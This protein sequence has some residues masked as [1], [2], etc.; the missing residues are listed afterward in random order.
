M[1]GLDRQL[2]MCSRC[3]YPDDVS[4]GELVLDHVR[5][6]IDSVRAA[7]LIGANESRKETQCSIARRV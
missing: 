1:H 5:Y 2:V 4:G 3:V 7:D 6:Q